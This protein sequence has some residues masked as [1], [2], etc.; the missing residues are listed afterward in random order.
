MVLLA[1]RVSAKRPPAK[2]TSTSSAE[3]IFLM[4]SK[5]SPACSFVSIQTLPFSLPL[6]LRGELAS[7][8]STPDLNPPKTGRRRTVAGAH[9][10]LG[11]SLP[12]VGSSPESPLV[13]RTDRI[14]RIPE[15]RRDP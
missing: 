6:W 12:A 1:K 3:E 8:E 15:F 11:L 14:Q 7:L 13:V 5:M 10:L 9:H 2:R 4:R